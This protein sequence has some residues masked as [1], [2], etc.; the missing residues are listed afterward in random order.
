MKYT[1]IIIELSEKFKKY[2]Q[3]KYQKN[4][5]LQKIL[6]IIAN[7]NKLSLKNKTKLSYKSEKNLLYQI[8]NNKNCFCIS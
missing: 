7:N 8:I 1:I 2:L 6:D 5:K 4:L 3:D